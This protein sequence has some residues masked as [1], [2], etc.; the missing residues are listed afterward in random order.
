METGAAYARATVFVSHLIHSFS[1]LP[2]NTTAGTE[3]P[4]I[5]NE[6]ITARARELW[7]KA[8]SPDG[9]DLEFWLGAEHELNHDRIEVSQA[10]HG[11]VTPPPATPGG[12]QATGEG[13]AQP[14]GARKTRRSAKQR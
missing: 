8:G 2:M 10:Q 14:S 13:T 5:T 11:D 4:R 9:R 3:S 7:Q 1:L 6:Q 12:G